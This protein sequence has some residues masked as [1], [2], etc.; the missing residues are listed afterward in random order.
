ME[1]GNI[2]EVITSTEDSEGFGQPGPPYFSQ[3]EFIRLEEALRGY[4]QIDGMVPHMAET[5][6]AFSQTTSLSE[7][8]MRVTAL[9][10]SRMDG[11]VPLATLD[12]EI[13][14]VEGLPDG[15][16]YLNERAA[17][18]LSAEAGPPHHTAHRRG[19]GRIRCG[20]SCPAGR[21]GG[22]EHLI[23]RPPFP[24]TGPAPLRPPGA[25]ST[26]SPTPTR[27]GSRDGADLSPRRY[28]STCGDCSQTRKW[29]PS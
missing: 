16:L 9:D 20:R 14:S 5:V 1:L 4:D 25:D 8:R 19:R 28:K 7:G 26:S 24:G 22:R 13:V 10:P 3:D 21:H 6:P 27:G 12:G 11:F 15:S 17:E 18:E 2:D 29:R 23:H